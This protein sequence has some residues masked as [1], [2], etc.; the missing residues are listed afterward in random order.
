LTLIVIAAIVVGGLLLIT[1]VIVIGIVAHSRQNQRQ[2]RT[3]A[4]AIPM[5]AAT[6]ENPACNKTTTFMATFDNHQLLLLV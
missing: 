3:E 6:S 5:N 4:A 1:C 2:E